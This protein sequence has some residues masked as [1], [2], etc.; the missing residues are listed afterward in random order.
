LLRWRGWEGDRGVGEEVGEMKGEKKRR[1]QD[2]KEK[3]KGERI[4]DARVSDLREREKEKT[5]ADSEVE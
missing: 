3:R 4:D 5:H 1:Q 2:E